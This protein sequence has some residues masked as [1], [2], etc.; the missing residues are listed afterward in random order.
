MQVIIKSSTNFPA[1][2]GAAAKCEEE[3]I[4]VCVRLFRY[5]LLG[6]GYAR[7]NVDDYV[8]EPPGLDEP[9]PLSV[10]INKQEAA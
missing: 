4:D 2:S 1:E 10:P 7:E 6:M 9:W 8:P 5:A 3:T